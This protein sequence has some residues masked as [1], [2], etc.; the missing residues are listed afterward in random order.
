MKLL[1]NELIEQRQPSNNTQFHFTIL[2]EN[3][4][5]EWN[6]FVE[7][8]AAQ[9][10]ASTLWNEVDVFPAEAAAAKS[11]TTNF[12]SFLKRKVKLFAARWRCWLWMMKRKFVF[13]ELWVNGGGTPQCSAMKRKQTNFLW[14]MKQQWAGP[15]HEWRQERAGDWLLNEWVMGCRPSAAPPFHFSN[16]WIAFIPAGLPVHLFLCCALSQLVC[17]P[18]KKERE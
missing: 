12:S 14:F 10:N 4:N 8:S 18:L 1:R 7:G 15:T 5:C 11:K 6:E 13:L 3:G 17:L 2:F 16:L 9:G